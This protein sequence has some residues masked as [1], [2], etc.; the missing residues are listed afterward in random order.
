LGGQV[1]VK[2]AYTA[3]DR[4]FMAQL[5]AIKSRKP[6]VIYVPGY[7]I[8]A[9]MIAK[10]AKQIRINAPLLGGDGWD[11]PQL[12]DLG[13]AALN[14]SY[15][16]NHYA[17]DD[18]SPANKEFVARY[19]AR[20]KSLDPDFL[21]ALG[22]DAVK[23]LADAIKRAK[24][25]EGPALQAALAGTKDFAGVTG[26]I[27]I[28]KNRGVIK[29]AVILKVQDGKFVYHATIQPNQTQSAD[30]AQEKIYEGKEVDQK[31]RII[32]RPMPQYTEQA[33]RN[34]TSE[35]VVLRVVFKSSGEIGDIKVIRDAP[36]GL[37]EECVRAAREIKFVP[38][39]KDGHPVSLYVKVEYSFDSY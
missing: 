8:E 26:S 10:Q 12:F 36:Y 18:P 15:I 27:S 22:Y 9:G 3:G 24:T 28:D 25:T 1:I 20:Y 5:A 16:V 19:K 39:M 14:G 31:A 7:Y 32:M 6:D 4:D 34:G 17:T 38:A 35:W 37:T 2:Q 21:A 33:R 23:M 13:G 11:S 30:Q 29:P